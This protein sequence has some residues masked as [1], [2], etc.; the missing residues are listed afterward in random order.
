GAGVEVHAAQLDVAKSAQVDKLIKKIQRTM[1]P[2]K[3]V[4]HAAGVL[5]DSRLTELDKAAFE[6][7]MAPKVSGAWNLHK[8]TE[9]LPL[10]YFILYSSISAL[11]GNI[12]QGN[13][14]AANAFLDGLAYFR[15]TQGLPGTSINWV[16]IKDVG[17][18]AREPTVLEFMERMGINAFTTDQALA[19][20]NYLLE[21]NP[22]QVGIID[23]DWSQWGKMQQ[24][25]T[26]SPKFHQLVVSKNNGHVDDDVTRL[27]SVLAQLDEAG[28]LNV[29]ENLIAKQVARVLRIPLAKL[30]IHQSLLDMGM[31]S[32]TGFELLTVIRTVLG[33]EVSPM[34]LMRGVSIVQMVRNLHAKLNFP[35]AKTDKAAQ[36]DSPEDV[37]SLLESMMPANVLD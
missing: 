23:M 31:D 34:E 6:T 17:M 9:S 18:A 32:L 5:A 36:Q 27:L 10:D 28:Q 24:S 21:L 1:P 35:E 8:A 15:R 37:E 19:S 2:L 3:G 7:V 22:I 12:G 16:A 29:L 4:I 26:T 13:Y 30:D 20:L 25:L 33:V 11:V 14:A